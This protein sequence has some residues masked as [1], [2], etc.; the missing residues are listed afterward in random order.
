M[1]LKQES[2]AAVQ[3]QHEEDDTLG[4]W[5][6]SGDQGEESAAVQNERPPSGS[7]AALRTTITLRHPLSKKSFS[8]LLDTGSTKSLVA[9]EVVSWFCGEVGILF[10]GEDRL[11]I[12]VPHWWYIVSVITV[13]YFMTTVPFLWYGPTGSRT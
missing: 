9:K 8:A 13:W 2:S 5:H 11:G 3:Q 4:Y 7:G 10:D 12:T 6:T 1:S